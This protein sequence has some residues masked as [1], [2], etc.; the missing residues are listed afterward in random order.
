MEVDE[1]SGG[2]RSKATFLKYN[3]FFDVT[4][5]SVGFTFLNETFDGFEF[6]ISSDLWE[7]FDRCMINGLV[8]NYF[9]T[10]KS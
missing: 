8:L 2:S 7:R 4:N 6:S 9:C 10:G 1:V 3:L 5:K